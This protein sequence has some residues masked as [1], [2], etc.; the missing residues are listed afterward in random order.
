MPHPTRSKEIIAFE[1][2]LPHSGDWVKGN[3]DGEAKVTLIVGV[4]AAAL[5][6]ARSEL[7]SE[8]TFVVKFEEE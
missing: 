5:L 4:K 3:R 7:L 8:K 1:A 6:L 2:T